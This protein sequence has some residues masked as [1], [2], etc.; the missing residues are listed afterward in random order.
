MIENRGIG[1]KGWGRDLER[2]FESLNF[3]VDNNIDSKRAFPLAGLDIERDKIGGIVLVGFTLV[4]APLAIT[5]Q[6]IDLDIEVSA[7]D[8]TATGLVLDKLDWFFAVGAMTNYR[9]IIW[10]SGAYVFAPGYCKLYVSKLCNGADFIRFSVIFD[11]AMDSKLLVC[12]IVGF[13]KAGP[14]RIPVMGYKPEIAGIE[15]N[16]FRFCRWIGLSV[17][18]DSPRIV[19]L[20]FKIIESRQRIIGFRR[21]FNGPLILGKGY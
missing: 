1:R 14:E 12:K 15:L 21:D 4:V 17:E 16:S 13:A 18:P 8:E 2:T 6:G 19:D 20:D 5:C 11:I 3:F 10:I 7:W 9:V